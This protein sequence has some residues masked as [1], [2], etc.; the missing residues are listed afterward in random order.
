MHKSEGRKEGGREGGHG[1]HWLLKIG[2]SP[3]VALGEGGRERGREG[4]TEGSCERAVREKAV[5]GWVQISAVHRGRKKEGKLEGNDGRKKGGK[6]GGRAGSYLSSTPSA[7][8]LPL[9]E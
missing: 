3:V 2:A 7:P 8:P 9:R 6:E 1:R 5:I 4:G